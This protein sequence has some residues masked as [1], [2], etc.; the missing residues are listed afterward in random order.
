MATIAHLYQNT[1]GEIP[2]NAQS[3]YGRTMCYEDVSVVGYEV[4]LVQARLTPRQ[5]ETPVTENWL[6]AR[7][8]QDNKMNLY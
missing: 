7:G 3:T 8:V 5:V 1:V 4:P 6:P 2:Q